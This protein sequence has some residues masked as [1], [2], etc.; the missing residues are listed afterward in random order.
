MY[1]R[2]SRRFFFT[3]QPPIDRIPQRWPSGLKRRLEDSP[4][5]SIPCVQRPFPVPQKKTGWTTRHWVLS[6][7]S[8][9]SCLIFGSYWF[10]GCLTRVRTDTSTCNSSICWS[11]ETRHPLDVLALYHIVL[12]TASY[13]LAKPIPSCLM[14]RASLLCTQLLSISPGRFQLHFWRRSRFQDHAEAV[15]W[16]ERNQ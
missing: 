7:E 5:R 14:I 2:L 11:V 16:T 1:Y 9:S 12:Q 15:L 4:R 3:L 13:I 8:V 10:V 6:S